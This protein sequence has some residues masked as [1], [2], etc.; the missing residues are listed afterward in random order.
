[1]NLQN[2]Y[3][4]LDNISSV[5]VDNSRL[6]VTVLDLD[7]VNLRVLKELSQSGVFVTGN[8]IKTL[9]KYDSKTIQAQLLK[10]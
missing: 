2:A 6:K 10:K 7:L 9:Y 1:M 4:G 5:E 3:G 8:V